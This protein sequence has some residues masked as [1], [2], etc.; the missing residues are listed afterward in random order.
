[1]SATSKKVLIRCDGAPEIGF[2]HVVRCLALADELRGSHG[3]R[4]DFAM[5]QGPQGVAK[6]QAQGYAVF[7]PNHGIED[8]DEGKWLKELI[9][10]CQYQVLILDV[11]TDLATDAV[12]SIRESGVLIATI[13]DPS[14]R[15]LH[16]DLAFYPPG[17]QVER[18]DWTGFTGDRFVGW[19]WVLLRPQFAEAVRK[20]WRSKSEALR[21]TLAEDTPMTVLITMGGSDPAGLTLMALEGIEQLD[22]NLHILLVIGG[23][24]MHETALHERLGT[25]KCHY[26][27]CRNVTDMAS[28][29][30]EAD[31]AIASF[32]VTA[33]ELA[34]MNVPTI[35]LC[36][37]EDHADSANAFVSAGLGN[38]LGQYSGVTLDSLTIAIEQALLS[39]HAN[40]RFCGSRDELPDGLGALR[41]ASRL[42][43]IFPNTLN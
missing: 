21:R 19:D 40:Q 35:Y 9:I 32:G 23:G 39:V 36:L 31:L 34:A 15:R 25:T 20:T 4:V 28:L 2:G 43:G 8:S 5:L 3:C 13:D 24:F 10:D 37:T 26:E 12:Q 11:R 22:A 42:C 33:Y 6:V 14:D 16:A 41:I 29:M 17:P 30:V 27:I 18:L 7:Q 1:M 38:S